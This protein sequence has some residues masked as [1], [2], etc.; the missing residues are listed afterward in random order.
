MVM[1]IVRNVWVNDTEILTRGRT[2]ASARDRDASQ[3]R[4]LPNH[5]VLS[6]DDQSQRVY[7]LLQRGVVLP[8]IIQ[9]IAELDD[10]F[11]HGN[12]GPACRA[13]RAH[14]RE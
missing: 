6:R 7:L 2:V 9:S 14:K 3:V 8:Q 11:A 1:V 10:L 13:R 4:K 5:S 12:V